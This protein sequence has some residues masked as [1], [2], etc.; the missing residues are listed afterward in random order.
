M[1]FGTGAPL[2]AGIVR[3]GA[4]AADG[5][6]VWSVHDGASFELLGDAR[7]G[8]TSAHGWGFAAPCSPAAAAGRV[9]RGPGGPPQRP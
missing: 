1:R 6:L 5:A 8:P 9:H 4:V 2:P 7:S 3:L